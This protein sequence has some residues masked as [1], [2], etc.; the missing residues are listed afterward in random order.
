VT[1]PRLAAP[2]PLRDGVAPS[3]AALPAGPWPTVLACLQARFTGVAPE[4]W[5]QRCLRGEV[6]D[7]HG[8]AVTPERPHEKQLRVFYYR[9]LP[10]EVVSAE[11]LP[12]VWQDAHLLVI[13]KPHF[14]AAIPG[15][16]HLKNTALVRLK[17]QT[18]EA[19]LAPLHR[20]DR[21]TAGLLVFSRQPATRGVYQRLFAERTVHKRYR[22]VVHWP[23][24]EGDAGWHV[25]EPSTHRSHM[26][27]DDHF[28]R[29]REVPGE[30][31]S[32][33]TLTLQTRWPEAGRAL[34]QLAP[35][36]GR[37]HQLRVHCAA[38]GCPIVGDTLY[39]V[40]QAMGSDDATLPL[41]LL[42]QWLSF[43]DPI[44]GEPRQFE[45]ALRLLAAG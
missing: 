40:L 42:A 23:P 39:P 32:E 33:T 4:V 8:V 20:L 10:D 36:T 3:I 34:L 7:E 41:Q 28:L 18:G 43:T 22:A 25:G 37:T 21:E 31:N 9:E 13:D 24:A 6:V 38:L 14:L 12:I 45:S 44:S 30:P 17:Q 26:A 15:G 5:H 2:L 11:P 19:D 27:Q 16:Q 1:R 29:M 35:L